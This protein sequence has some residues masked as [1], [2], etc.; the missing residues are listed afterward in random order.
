MPDCFV[1][2]DVAKDELCIALHGQEAVESFANDQKGLAK[3]CKRV[4]KAKPLLVVLEAT[5]GYERGVVVALGSAGLPVVVVNPRQVRDFARATGRLAKTDAIDARA[6]A[7]FAQA[8]RP[9]VR[10]LPD[11]ECREMADLLAHRRSLVHMRTAQTNRLKQTTVERVA[12]DIR[13]VIE[14][15]ERQIKA[16]DDDLDD[17]IQRSVEWKQKAE[18]LESTPGVG[19]QTARAL[20][21][22]M[23]ELG[24]VSRQE[25]AGLVGTAPMNRDS[26]QMR[27][28]RI[29]QGG[30][31]HVRSVL[32]MATLSATRANPA[33]RAMYNRLLAAG[34]VKKV[35]LV[36]CM[37]KL[38][39]ILNAMIREN[40]KWNESPKTA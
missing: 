15:L 40:R 7:H 39:T 2:I 34:K 6:I 20:I 26:G 29:T 12:S 16:V 18:I 27:G 23:P 33:I 11:A 35:A 10:P 36:A 24:T 13:K 38:I 17:R 4:V 14:L 1:G 9:A 22:D 28:R 30:R 32:Y 31:G 25:I 19:E 3:L 21:V 37:R 8:V 5:G